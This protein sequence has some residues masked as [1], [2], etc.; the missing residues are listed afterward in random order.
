[1]IIRGNTVGTTMKRPIV[2]ITSIDNSYQTLADLPV[3]V[4][5]GTSLLVNS[6]ETVYSYDANLG[7]W[8][9]VEALRSRTTYA[10][11][12]GAKK[13]LYR[14]I[15]TPPYLAPIAEPTPTQLSAF[16]ND[17]GY[18]T[19]HDIRGKQDSLVFDGVYDASSNPVATLFTVQQS[20][21][22]SIISL[23][24]EGHQLTYIKADGSKHTITI[25]DDNTEYS[26]GTDEKT[27]LTKI[28]A[29]T[30]NA[31]DGTMTQKAITEELKKKV[32]VDVN[33]AHNSLIFSTD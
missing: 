17:A 23:L 9:R 14:Y 20:A 27:G 28:Y 21:N 7:I 11:L 12:T 4:S 1:M 13:G 6:E 30:G 29:T 2:N 18:L 15:P 33:N 25:P 5:N 8:K 24:I 3:N 19:K 22:E 10:V 16:D 26:L 31:E 32:S